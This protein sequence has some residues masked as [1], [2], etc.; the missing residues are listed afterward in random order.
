LI[1]IRV[2]CCTVTG[3]NDDNREDVEWCVTTTRFEKEAREAARQLFYRLKPLGVGD[4]SGKLSAQDFAAG[5]GLLS[6]S[7]KEQKLLEKAG[8]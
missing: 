2:F 1:V 5:I 8:C 3:I 7:K 4:A 6:V